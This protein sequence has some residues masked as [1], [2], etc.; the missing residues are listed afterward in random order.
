MAAF[1]ATM[2][3]P[4][5]GNRPIAIAAPS[6]SPITAEHSVDVRLTA[7]ESPTIA[8]RRGS[9]CA[10][11]W[12]ASAKLC[13]MVSIGTAYCA[14]GLQSYA[15]LTCARRKSS[16]LPQHGERRLAHRLARAEPS[17]DQH[18]K[19]P[20]HDA[21]QPDERIRGERN[22]EH[23]IGERPPDRRRAGSTEQA[24]KRAEQQE[25]GRLRA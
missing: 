10:T 7:I 11:M 13:E 3:G 2:T 5:P 8:A 22:I 16:E 17:R 6:G 25:L 24:R 4:R 23:A 14:A 12:S 18:G 15:I 21:V 9:R 20:A 19:R 1:N